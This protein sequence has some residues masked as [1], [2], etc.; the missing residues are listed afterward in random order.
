MN[1]K[2]RRHQPFHIACLP[3]QCKTDEERI[4]QS[5][6]SHLRS[7]RPHLS[8]HVYRLYEHSVAWTISARVPTDPSKFNSAGSIQAVKTDTGEIIGYARFSVSGL[9]AKFP[10]SAESSP[11]TSKDEF[12]V[13]GKEFQTPSMTSESSSETNKLSSTPDL[14]GPTLISTFP[15]PDP[16]FMKNLAEGYQKAMT[17]FFPNDQP[18][19][20][21]ENLVVAAGAQRMGVGSMLLKAVGEAAKK[22][23]LG[24]CLIATEDVGRSFF[25][26]KVRSD[27]APVILILIIHSLM[28]LAGLRSVLKERVQSGG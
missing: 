28:T 7:V 15:Q 16:D 6:S 5:V 9:Q 22:E 25:P 13:E 19:I 14:G 11:A 18:R 21:L 17:T 27:D 2:A 1:Y 12:V 20:T 23:G 4:G 26:P 10:S 24:I 8:D 3:R